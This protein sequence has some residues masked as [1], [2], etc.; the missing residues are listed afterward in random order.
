[1]SPPTGAS[2]AHLDCAA[3]T[4][5]LRGVRVPTNEQRREAAKRK[6]DRQ[7]ARRAKRAK[8]RRLYAVVGSA[9]A[10][11]LVVGLVVLITMLSGGEEQENAAEPTA[12]D[13]PA[14]TSEPVQIPSEIAP[15][16]T[17]TQPLPATV[18][19]QYPAN[20]QPPA[21]PVQPPPP[22]P[23][24]AEGTVEVTLQ[25]S[26]GAVPTTLYRAI[27]P[28]TVASFLS[29]SQQGYYNDTPCHRLTTSPSLGVLQCGDPTGQGTG[30]PG[31]NL[32]DELV[33]GTVYGRGYLAMANTGQ[34]NSGGGQFFIVYGSANA[35]NSNPTYT[36]FGTIGAEGLA[37]IDEVA[38]AGV[39]GGGQDG[40][41]ATPVQIQQVV[42]EP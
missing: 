28:C 32:P 41:P 34:P 11:V 3:F 35:L 31:Y 24:P 38:L 9:A 30:G 8:R 42:I 16:P 40:P 18:D 14:P 37:T 15:P 1:M 33:E 17:R 22:G 13:L 7:L 4:T 26:V 39:E 20:P 19:C 21:R 23:T 27:A 36:V 2:G 6:L 5:E 25:T 12:V 29:L 10:V